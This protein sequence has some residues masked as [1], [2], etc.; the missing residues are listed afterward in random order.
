[1]S[2]KSHISS[3]RFSGTLTLS[4]AVAIVLACA[5][6]LTS[7][8][9]LPLLSQYLWDSETTDIVSSLVVAFLVQLPLVLSSCE[10][11]SSLPRSSGISQLSFIS[12]SPLLVF[13]LEWLLLGGYLVIA[14]LLTS[15]LLANFVILNDVVVGI[16]LPIPVLTIGLLLLVFTSLALTAVARVTVYR[17]TVFLGL[18]LLLGA[19][20]WTLVAGLP[21]NAPT[22]AGPAPEYSL[23]HPLIGVALLGVGVWFLPLLIEK[24]HLLRWGNRATIQGS[25][26]GWGISLIIALALIA[27]V[28]LTVVLSPTQVTGGG[29]THTAPLLGLTIS[30]IVLLWVGLATLISAAVRTSIGMSSA[31]FLPSTSYLQFRSNDSH[32]ETTAR[33]DLFLRNCVVLGAIALLSLLR[34]PTSLLFT[35]ATMIHLAGLTL[36]APFI[37]TSHLELPKTRW[38]KLP[39]HPLLPLSST[40]LAGFFAVMLLIVEPFS[41]ITWTLVGAILYLVYGKAANL[42]L[43]QKDVLITDTEQELPDDIY[44]IA[45][46]T[47]GD[48][49]IDA[50]FGLAATLAEHHDRTTRIGSSTLADQE[51]ATPSQEPTTRILS[52]RIVTGDER[53]PAYLI[54]REALR[55]LEKLQGIIDSV[56]VEDSQTTAVQP[57]IRIAPGITPGVLEVIR[58]LDVDLII[59]AGEPNGASDADPAA[60]DIEQLLHGTTRPVLIVSGKLAKQP[61]SIALAVGTT[62]H[63]RAALKLADTLASSYLQKPEVSVLRVAT[64]SVAQQQDQIVID[65]LLKDYVPE[66]ALEQRLVHAPKIATGLLQESRAT[67]ILVMGVAVDTGLRTTSIAGLPQD[68]AN[69][70]QQATIIVKGGESMRYFWSRKLLSLIS[71]I[72]PQLPRE[73]QAEVYA[74]MGRAAKATIDFYVL[75]FL[76]SAIATLGLLL[77]S[78]GVIIGA[79]LVAPLMSPILAIATGVVHG[80]LL[81]IRRGVRSTL[82][83]ILLALAVST[84]ITILTPMQLADSEILARTQPNMLDLFVALAAGAAAAYGVSRES[85]PAALPGVAISVALVPPLCVVGFGLGASDFA[86]AGGALLLF[87]TNFSAIIVI[88]AVVFYLLGFRPTEASRKGRFER[89]VAVALL[90][91]ALITIPLG[92]STRH[93]AQIHSLKLRVSRIIARQVAE[94]MTITNFQVSSRRGIFTVNLAIDAYQD[95]ITRHDLRRAQTALSKSIGAPVRLRATVRKAELFEIGP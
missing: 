38:L 88:G 37:A 34:S 27:T 16:D 60:V 43:R 85:V 11:A 25:L 20:G 52:L 73:Q 10:L 18:L 41:T 15:A 23:E 33:L 80:N 2:N 31:G 76:A 26:I 53:L 87:L 48:S 95:D 94:R 47:Q 89:A 24:Q 65:S 39:L 21:P 9:A 35:A 68:V 8:V 82:L 66:S 81:M 7:F 36:T 49:K 29:S 44:T 93:F 90:L 79:M 58:E 57:I 4:D 75:M 42:D 50:L 46:L 71:S 12:K 1:M 63:A 19:L 54:K 61:R 86:T 92:F 69:N 77:N 45:V 72:L 78:S 5:I 55:E 28:P 14:S 91:L 56:R 64:S 62:A 13:T 83:G 74:Q 51:Q 67:D 32:H 70:R 22:I 17:Q 30:K 84:T 3:V 59:L 40:I 6:P